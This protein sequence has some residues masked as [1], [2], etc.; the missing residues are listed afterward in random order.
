MRYR[1]IKEACRGRLLEIPTCHEASREERIAVLRFNLQ[2]MR[3]EMGRIAPFYPQSEKDVPDWIDRHDATTG[4]LEA[5]IRK[6]AD[7]PD[8]SELPSPFPT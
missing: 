5:V 3:E 6:V 2:V 4:R 8:D 1:T 7:L